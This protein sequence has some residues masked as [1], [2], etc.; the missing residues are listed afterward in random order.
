[1]AD[2]LHRLY[3]T[4]LTLLATWSLVLGIVCLVLAKWAA[5]STEAAWL[6]FIPLGEIGATLFGSG[7]IVVAWTYID[8]K[9]GDAR[10]REQ[11][12]QVLCEEAPAIRDSVVHGFADSAEALA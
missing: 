3:K 7:L 6:Q 1:M 4:K 9:D 10:T 8:K 2:P 12:R 11:F 5:G